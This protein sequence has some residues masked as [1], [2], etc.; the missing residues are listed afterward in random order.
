MSK[1]ETTAKTFGKM[2]SFFWP[3]HSFELKKLVP[4]LM[5][6]FLILFNYTILRDTKDTL[7]VTSAGGAE[8][9]PFLKLGATLPAAV[10]FLLIY[11]KLS[12]KVSK[13]K[14]FYLAVA[15]FIA[16]F[17]LFSTV[18]Y[19]MRELLAPTEFCNWLLTVFPANLSPIVESIR[20]WPFSVFYVMSELWGSVALSLLFWGF[21][22]DITKPAEAKRFY[23]LFGLGAN[24]SLIL[25]GTCI[26]AV[27]K[28][29]SGLAA[30]AGVDP[31]QISLNYLMLMVVVSGVLIM[32]IYWWITKNVLTD[33]RFYSPDEIKKS[34]KEKPK[35][36]LKDSFKHLL[37]SKYMGCLALLVIGYGICIN[38]VEVAWKSQLKL[39]YP[40]PNAYSTF[41][42][43]FSRMTGIV[44]ILMMFFVTGN[45]VRKLGW[46]TA[47]MITPVVLLIT[48]GLFFTFVV[49]SESLTGFIAYF[50][51]SPLMLAV[52]FG[53]AQNIMSKSSK[54]SLFDPTKEMAYIPCTQDEKVTGK[55][56][57]DVVGA[58]LGKSGGALI[59]SV[60]IYG[61][62]GNV[63]T[64]V[65]YI[66]AILFV[67]IGAWIIAANS[68]SKQFATLS[69][70][71]EA[72]EAE[73]AT[74]P[75]VGATPAT[76]A[77]TVTKMEQ[78]TTS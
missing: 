45:V 43:G 33:T 73:E 35:M 78:T 57:I 48:G 51:T 6:F 68:L 14:L 54:Y 17:G 40:D 26:I 60:F 4:M 23:G 76:E 32:G 49:F 64:A 66:G 63:I 47:A 75:T 74:T 22:N 21:A 55:G 44:T 8:A 30:T 12:T 38:L 15:P 61:I 72:E 62:F 11:S 36:G 59:N 20:V 2:R 58:R 65:P 37:K 50:G 31:W 46:R 18:I 70:K 3:I 71:K 5:L 34:K 53:T 13:Q 56:A 1:T 41:M 67:I 25:A 24:F 42:G 69:Q 39:A 7:I 27:S 16:F 10:L 19:P 29:R 77:S 28:L 52:I 9:I